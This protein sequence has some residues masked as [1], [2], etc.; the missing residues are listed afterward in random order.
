MLTG[1]RAGTAR[2]FFVLIVLLAAAAPARAADKSLAARTEI[3]LIY[4]GGAPIGYSV[5]TLKKQKTAKGDYARWAIESELYMRLGIKNAF[6]DTFQKTTEI[7]GE[8]LRLQEM[9]SLLILGGDMYHLTAESDNASLFVTTKRGGNTHRAEVAYPVGTVPLNAAPLLLA[10]LDMAK[11]P[12]GRNIK[13]VSP[14][15][16]SLSVAEM[17]VYVEGDAAVTFGGKIL[18]VLLVR[19]ELDGMDTLLKIDKNGSVY[20]SVQPTMGLLQ[21]RVNLENLME[22]KDFQG[23]DVSGSTL[24][25]SD[26]KLPNSE[27]VEWIDA[28]INWTGDADLSLASDHQKVLDSR[29]RRGSGFAKVRITRTA[30]QPVKENLSEAQR[31]QYLAANA[32]IQTSDPAVIKAS[33]QAAGVEK[34]PRK[35][36]EY[37]ARWIHQNIYPDPATWTN[38]HAAGTTLERGAGMNKHMAILF[39]AMARHRGIPTRV[40]AGMIYTGGLFLSYFWNEAYINGEWVTVDATA[41]DPLR[42][43]PV[44]IKLTH[45][46]DTEVAGDRS[47]PIMKSLRISIISTQTR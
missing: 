17:G 4:K 38:D 44:R 12:K 41:P 30:A 43:P 22:V 25:P 47:E 32:K 42:P 40:A 20:E 26:R 14:G 3:F 11:G 37:I 8:N 46:P 39:A 7:I 9:E 27:T 36:V 16:S 35:Q 29:F 23:W 18:D 1:I 2:F 24:F 10:R 31:R 6:Q 45:G 5:S 28:E 21:R 34:D 15:L 33:N 13:V 19:T